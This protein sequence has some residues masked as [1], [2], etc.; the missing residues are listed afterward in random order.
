MLSQASAKVG[1]EKARYVK[2]AALPE[3]V[4]H[5]GATSKAFSK[6]YPGANVLGASRYRSM[7]TVQ[8]NCALSHAAT[9][10]VYQARASE[11]KAF[12][13]MRQISC[14]ARLNHN[15]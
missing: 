2:T 9:Y 13:L 1:S 15:H 10:Q 4:P 11:E 8:D 14:E 6:L 7:Q 3:S 12:G 5:V